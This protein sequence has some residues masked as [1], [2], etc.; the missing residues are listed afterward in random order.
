MTGTLCLLAAAQRGSWQL[1]LL[2]ILV[3]L[4]GVALS[5]LF[6]SSQPMWLSCFEKL[7]YLMMPVLPKV[8]SIIS[9]ICIIMH[10]CDSDTQSV[11]H[12]K[13]SLI[14]RLHNCFIALFQIVPL[15]STRLHVSARVIV[16]G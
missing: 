9:S 3:S 6:S 5:A 8:E 13:L 4:G 16:T 7:H 11:F 15:A 10:D 12:A 1:S 14:Y 2:K